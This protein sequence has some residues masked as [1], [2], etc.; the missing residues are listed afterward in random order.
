MDLIWSHISPD[1]GHCHEYKNTCPALWIIQKTSF[2]FHRH[3]LQSARLNF[4]N[5][6]FRKRIVFLRYGPIFLGKMFFMYNDE[7]IRIIDSR[8]LIWNKTNTNYMIQ[9]RS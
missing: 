8:Y 7:R 3:V 1:L 2:W 9:V 5:E 4:K 6:E